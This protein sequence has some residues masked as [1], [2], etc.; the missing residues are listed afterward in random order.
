[1]K[2]WS[3]FQRFSF[4]YSIAVMVKIVMCVKNY[5]FGMAKSI[6]VVAALT[7]GLASVTAVLSPVAMAAAE[8]GQKLS[9]KMKPLGDAQKL[10]GEKKWK[11]ALAVI[12][13]KV[14]PI[15]G[16]SAYEESLTNEM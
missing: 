3:N 4:K 13:E 6:T 7:T 10:M 12:N 5:L 11:E 16:K 15:T 9:S 8:K 2:R 14:V 1:M